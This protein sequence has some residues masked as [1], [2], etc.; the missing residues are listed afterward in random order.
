MKNWPAVPKTIPVGDCTLVITDED[1]LT[2]Y[3]TGHL[4][5]LSDGRAFRFSDKNLTTV[6]MKSLEDMKRP[7]AY[8]VGYIVGWLVALAS[9]E[10]E[11]PDKTCTEEKE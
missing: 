11:Q 1:F 3:Q 10:H 8:C 5:F 9:H 2:G 4:A 7:E 6:I